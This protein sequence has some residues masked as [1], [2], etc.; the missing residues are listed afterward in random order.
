M[1]CLHWDL[2]ISLI[3]DILVLVV[4]IVLQIDTIRILLIV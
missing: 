2:L 1:M 3:P 4:C